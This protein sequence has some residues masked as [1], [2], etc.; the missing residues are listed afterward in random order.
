[1]VGNGS[2]I[3]VGYGEPYPRASV[4]KSKRYAGTELQIVGSIVQRAE[5]N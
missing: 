3:P 2:E 1:M 4:S 5:A